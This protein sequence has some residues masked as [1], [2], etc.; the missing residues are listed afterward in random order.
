MNKLRAHVTT[1][2]LVSLFA[3]SCASLLLK[4]YNK[5]FEAVSK[6]VIILVV[7]ALVISIGVFLVVLYRAL[8][9]EI[10]KGRR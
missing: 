6:V 1:S 10:H 3:F 4:D 7:I 9:N 2:T 5:F 8:Y